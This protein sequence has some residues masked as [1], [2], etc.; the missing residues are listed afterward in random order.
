MAKWETVPLVAIPTFTAS[1]FNLVPTTCA[2]YHYAFALCNALPCS[3]RHLLFPIVGTRPRRNTSQQIKSSLYYRMS[4]NCCQ[5][6]CPL[7]CLHTL[8]LLLSYFPPLSYDD[9]RRRKVVTLELQHLFISYT[10]A[11]HCSSE[12]FQL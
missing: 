3:A 5:I 2:R 9:C 6:R 7:F 4:N 8:Y 11:G 1:P 12:H 10:V